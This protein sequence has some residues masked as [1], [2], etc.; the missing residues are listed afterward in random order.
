MNLKI[1]KLQLLAILF[2][3]ILFATPLLMTSIH[4]NITVGNL[5]HKAITSGHPCVALIGD[6][7]GGGGIPMVQ[8]NGSQ[9]I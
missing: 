7:V 3:A 2:F 5:F 6:P 1:G 9:Q 4:A 8:P